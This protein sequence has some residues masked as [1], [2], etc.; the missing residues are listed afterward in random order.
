MPIS[1]LSDANWEKSNVDQPTNDLMSSN[2]NFFYV[3]L[4]FKKTW[5]QGGHFAALVP[6]L[7]LP[8]TVSSVRTLRYDIGSVNTGKYI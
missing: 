5:S 6:T 2:A 7:A 1:G 4:E 3:S 8:S